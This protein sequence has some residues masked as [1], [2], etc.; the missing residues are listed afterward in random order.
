M[1]LQK[2]LFGT[3]SKGKIGEMLKHFGN[4]NWQIYFTKDFKIPEPEETGETFEENAVLK[5]KYY[6]DLANIP[7]IADDSG[8]VVTQLGNFPGV[9]TKRFAEEECGSYYKAFDKINEMLK[10]FEPPYPIK[11]VTALAFYNPIKNQIITVNGEIK[12]TFFYPPKGDEIEGY[13]YLPIFLPENSDKTFAELEEDGENIRDFYRS[14]IFK[15]LIT[16]LENFYI[17]D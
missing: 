5:A 12:G 16:K 6:G 13:G 1:K 3:N 10:D 17:N 8:L 11:M 15:E 4:R 7:T 2:I 9:R 14:K